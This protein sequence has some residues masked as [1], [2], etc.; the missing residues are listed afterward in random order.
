MGE[1]EELGSLRGVAVSSGSLEGSCS[2]TSEREP[3]SPL[4]L[5]ANSIRSHSFLGY[6]NMCLFSL[7]LL[8]LPDPSIIPSTHNA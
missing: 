2:T 3:E 4:P 1:S 6:Q 5:L 8:L 7:L